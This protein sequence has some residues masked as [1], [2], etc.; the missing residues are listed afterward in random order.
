MKYE[1]FVINKAKT[2][3]LPNLNINEA[4]MAIIL[5]EGSKDTLNGPK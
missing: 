1:G 4:K 3:T 5:S 2:A